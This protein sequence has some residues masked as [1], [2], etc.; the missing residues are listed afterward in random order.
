MLLKAVQ[1]WLRKCFKASQTAP[2]KPELDKRLELIFNTHENWKD[3]TNIKYTFDWFNLSFNTF[4]ETKK[5]KLYNPKNDF[6][7]EISGQLGDFNNI[8]C[9][10]LKQP[11]GIINW[12]RFFVDICY[13]SLMK[14]NL[15]KDRLR[16]S[17]L[18]DF[19]FIEMILDVIRSTRRSKK[20]Q[21][22]SND[23]L[24][25]KMITH[26]SALHWRY[27]LKDF[28]HLRSNG[29]ENSKINSIR[30]DPTNLV[31]KVLAEMKKI[32]ATNILLFRIR[33]DTY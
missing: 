24:K 25:S 9:V 20:I 7:E 30:A 1:D 32:N 4:D 6:Q 21:Q 11:F 33:I 23:F 15:A 18:Y 5:V 10:M 17:N 8:N 27:D 16:A 22:I 12:V 3:L 13:Y 31:K 29:K 19:E 28:L 2:Y 14:N 26:F